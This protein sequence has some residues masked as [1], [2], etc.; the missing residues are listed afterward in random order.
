MCSVFISRNVYIN[1]VVILSVMDMV[2]IL[3]VT[4]VPFEG[5][6]FS[7]TEPQVDGPLSIVVV[8]STDLLAF[9]FSHFH[10]LYFFVN[11]QRKFR[12]NPSNSC[13]ISAC[14]CLPCIS[15]VPQFYR[16]EIQVFSLPCNVWL[17]HEHI[18]DGL[19]LHTSDWYRVDS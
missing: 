4:H 7:A 9:S 12:Y 5:L 6:T 15:L 19:L 17:L 10:Q 2:I 11:T 1:T 8:I 14:G 3:S 16:V 18:F 13:F